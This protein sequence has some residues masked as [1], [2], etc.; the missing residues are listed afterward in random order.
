MLWVPT[1]FEHPKH[2][3]KLMY[4]K[5]VA[6]LRYFCFS[7]TGPMM[8]ILEAAGG[9]VPPHPQ[10]PRTFYTNATYYPFPQQKNLTF[11]IV[12]TTNGGRNNNSTPPPPSKK[13]KQN[14]TRPS[15]N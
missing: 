8:Y 6:I 14:K 12:T 3:S 15:F 7:L 10:K 5:I 4:K 2:M 9:A 11:D 1:F 13:K